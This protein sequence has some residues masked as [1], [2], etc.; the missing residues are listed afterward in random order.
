M[1]GA[2][3]AIR[4][5]SKRISR[6]RQAGARPYG[7]SP[8]LPAI[9]GG[10]LAS[11]DWSGPMAKLVSVTLAYGTY[12][13]L[14]KPLVHV[15]TSWPANAPLKYGLGEELA[16]FGQRDDAVKRRDWKAMNRLLTP[17]SEAG[18]HA[19]RNAVVEVNG[20][21]LDVVMNTRDIY[22][23]VRATLA[24][25]TVTVVMRYPLDNIPLTVVE[26]M[27]PYFAACLETLRTWPAFE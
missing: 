8:V 2:E 14:A 11:E 20:Q 17:R 21:Q 6:L 4:L 7:L 18:E 25:A 26:D 5:A 1:P 24:E 12:F 27:E 13:D 3:L 10:M 22:G 19:L 15:T 23:A 9:S 16:L